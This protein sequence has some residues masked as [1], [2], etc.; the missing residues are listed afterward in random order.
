MFVYVY[1]CT[2]YLC[3][4]YL[5]CCLECGSVSLILFARFHV[6]VIIGTMERTPT[7]RVTYVTSCVTTDT[8]M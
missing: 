1:T 8:V 4:V 7:E 3:I 5:I 2:L 6:K